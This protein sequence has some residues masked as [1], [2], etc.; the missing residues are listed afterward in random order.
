[1]SC[2]ILVKELLNPDRW[3]KLERLKSEYA[4]ES[5]YKLYFR[6]SN[7]IDLV[8][9]VVFQNNHLEIITAYSK[10]RKIKPRFINRR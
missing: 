6:S 5:K 2:D 3:Y 8:I 10:N 7:R 1:M 4:H 9:I